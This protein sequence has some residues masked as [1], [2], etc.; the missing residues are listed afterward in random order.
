MKKKTGKNQKIT[1]GMSSAVLLSIA[2]HAALFFLAGMLVVFTVVKKKEQKFEPPKAV[3]RP[4]M[5][6]KKPK[7]KVKK[8]AR[9]K[10]AKHILAKVNPVNMSEIQLPEISGG[11]LGG[12]L[13]QGIGG[14]FDTLPDLSEPTL[15]G[16]TQSIGNDFVGTFY[17]FKRDRRGRNTPMSTQGYTASVAKFVRS[18]WKSSYLSSRYYHAPRK[19]YATTFMVPPVFSVVAPEVFGEPDTIPYA[20][21]V[22]Y[23]GQLVHKDDITFR[24]WGMGD[25]VLVVRVDGEVVLNACWPTASGYHGVPAIASFWQSSSADSH[26]YYMGNNVAVVGDWITLEAGVPLDME[27]LVGEVGGGYF[28]AMLAV[29]VEGVEYGKGPQGNPIL[30]I[31]KTSVP[32]LDMVETIHE[33]LV[34]GEVCVTNGPVFCDFDTSGSATANREPETIEPPVFADSV[35]NEMR[36]WTGADGKTLEAEFVTVIGGKAV[37]KDMREKV[38]KIPF[39]QLSDDDRLYIEL[40]QPPKFN[41]DFSKKSSQRLI[42]DSPAISVTGLMPKHLDYVFGARLKQVS[43]GEYNHELKVEFF[44]IGEEVDGDNHIL[45]DRRESRFTPCKENDRSH[46]FHGETIPLRK[47]TM[48]TQHRGKKYGGYMVV[49]TDERGMVIDTGTSHKWLPDILG[50]LRRLPLGKHFD[51]T[52]ARVEPPRPK[53]IGVY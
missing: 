40:A 25:D 29:E 47:Y 23:K 18:G 31:F 3:E 27:V 48:F 33:N 14:G 28:T 51:K 8:S 7:P 12:G 41:I 20:W 44:A 38:R 9:P 2:I 6:L 30:P 34:P 11:G 5:K 1:K 52:G 35:E 45:L 10:Q 36:T 26:K 37:L 53:P 24:F 15:F 22:H 21:A 16:A 32:S 42:E 43:A 49:V 13:G 17:D 46:E 19:L 39:A 4:K 50:N